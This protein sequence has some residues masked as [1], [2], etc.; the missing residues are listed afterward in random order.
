MLCHGV[1]SPG[2][3]AKYV[4]YLEKRFHAKLSHL[5]LRHKRKGWEMPSTVAF[6][7]DGREHALTGC[8]NSF[9]YGFLS[10]LTLRAACYRCPYTNI[11]RNGD[12]TLADFWGIGDYAP[13]HHNTKN[14]ISL[15]LVNSE[16]GQRLFEGSSNKIN[17]E[18][19]SLEE[20]KYERG[21]LKHPIPE[22]KSR[23]QFFVDYQFLDY[24]ALAKR[25]LV[26]KGM[27]GLIRRIVP[28]TRILKIRKII[29]K[30]I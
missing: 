27:K 6:F 18:E 28:R 10:C 30:I 2:L 19:R 4:A 23:K 21:R 12:I 17:S 8:D 16:K 15:I 22:P 1:P 20:A 13:F 11:D 29:K 25:H 24:E 14:G 26:D 7:D 5:N 3:F 9:M